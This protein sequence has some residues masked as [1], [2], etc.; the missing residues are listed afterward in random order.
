RRRGGGQGVR[1]GKR[2]VRGRTA[3]RLRLTFPHRDAPVGEAA[4]A[5]GGQHRKLDDEA[6]P[7][8]VVIGQGVEAGQLLALGTLAVACMEE[9][10]AM[11]GGG[12]GGGGDRGVHA[13]AHADHGERTWRGQMPRSTPGQRYL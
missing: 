4:A 8:G 11:T 13:P 12:G 3:V 2:Y 9:G 5:D 7:G 1:V 10:Q 6:R